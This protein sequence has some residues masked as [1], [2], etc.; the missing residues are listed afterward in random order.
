MKK[1]HFI[2]PMAGFGTRTSD[3]Y[4][5]PKPLIEVYDK[6][7]FEYALDG[8]KEISSY[9]MSCHPKITMIV[10]DDMFDEYDE[11]VVYNKIWG[12]YKYP[13]EFNIVKIDKPTRGS[14]ETVMKAK[15]LIDDTDICIVL[16]C[17]LWFKSNDLINILFRIDEQEDIDG[18]LLSFESDKPIYSYASITNNNY[19]TR[20]A[21]KQVISNHALAGVYGFAS[22]KIFKQ[23]AE[24]L[25]NRPSD[26]N[27]YYV[28]AIYNYMIKDGAKI[29]LSY[30]NEYA[31]LGTSEEIEEFK[32]SDNN[33]KHLHITDFDGTLVDTREAN[34]LAYKETFKKIY[35]YNLKP[36]DYYNNYGLRINELL[37]KLNLDIEKLNDVKKTKTRIYKKH[38]DKIKLN[39]HLLSLLRY[40]KDKGN[41]VTLATTAS[42]KNVNNILKH[43]ELLEFFDHIVYGEDV[44]NGKPD[45]EVYYKMLNKYY[46]INNDNIHIYED[47]DVGIL[48]AVKSGIN[49]N[50]LIIV[51]EFYETY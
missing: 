44:E 10:R 43:F 27:E 19:V 28:S 40:Q 31:S 33:F 29:K 34:Y 26:Y 6:C 2:M 21:E 36:E 20:T 3:K 16:D 9:S 17:D 42:K 50:N 7:L 51:D 48:A 4:T 35:D 47:S 49:L 5:V 24:Y 32:K 37:E 8:L 11:Y 41:Y 22:G 23:Y 25:L 46:W 12:D 13:Q 1:L 14:L 39:E 15:H 30:L 18:F 45:P 38:F